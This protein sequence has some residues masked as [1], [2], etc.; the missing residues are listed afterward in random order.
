MSI[1]WTSD[2]RSWLSFAAR[3]VGSV[4]LADLLMQEKHAFAAKVAPE[5]SDPAPHFAPRATRVIHVCLFGGLS[6]VD[7]FDYK[8]AL[9]QL[10]GKSLQS[11]EKPDV[12]FGRVGLLRK[13][14]WAFQQ[15]G[16]SGLWVSELFPHL[17]SVAD[18][19]TVVNSMFGETSNHTPATFQQNTG[20][21]LNGFPTFGAWMSYGL[22][23]ETDELPSYIV[24]PDPRGLPAGGSINWSNGFLPARHQGV[25]M[26]SKG[27]AIDD[28]FP[29]KEIPLQQEN[30]SRALLA[31]INRRHLEARRHDDQ[32]DA[33]IRGYALAAKMQMAVPEVTNL[34]RESKSTHAMYGMGQEET[35]DFG[36]SCLLAR[37]LLEQ[38]VR[39]VQLY[40]GGAFGSPRINW[41][42]HEDVAKNH[43][44]EAKRIDKPLSGLI[45]DLRQRGMLEDT[46]LL[47]SSEFGRTPFTQ[48]ASDKVGTG[49]D[50]N[51]K[52]FSIWMAGAGMPGGRTYGA[53]D[54]IG[55]QAV[56]KRLSWHDLHASVLSLLGI[57]HERL[58]IYHNGIQRRLT[59]VHGHAVKELIG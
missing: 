8:P 31:E 12:F 35:D 25:L 26:R 23:S 10:H 7:S 20:F 56:E 5:A 30:D 4:A 49:R 41:D 16:E 59:N 40:S 42:G 21:R 22:G 52:G 29:A 38:G 28:L 46:L 48:S 55:W 50:H 44:R 19:L 47:F 37:R 32:L 43:G 34:S 27:V 58:T 53:T 45:R 51:E 11:D 54:E 18:E 9:E 1:D 57:D 17:G 3:G 36:R 24:I 15:R 14:D 2:R 6:Q 33:R 39:F 13:N